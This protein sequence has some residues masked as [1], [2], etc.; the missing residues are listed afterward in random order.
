[1][2][3]G[4]RVRHYVHI[5]TGNYNPKTARIYTDLGLFTADPEIG[6]DVAE[7]FNFITGYGRP[8]DYRKVLVSPTTMRKRI[9]EEIEETIEAKRRGE[10]ARIA[11]KMNS[12]VD[13]RKIRALYEASQAG[14]RVDLN[15]RGICCLRPG[16]P[17]VSVSVFANSVVGRFLEHSRIYLFQRGD[18]TRVYVGSADLMPRNL[19]HRVELVAPVEEPALRDE[20]VDIVERALAD[21]RSSWTLDADGRWSRREPDAERPRSVQDE[22]RDWH[23]ARAAEHLVSA[24]E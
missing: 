10:P 18:E 22:L 19:D 20:A 12:L 17:G 21:D 7:M 2:R 1:R 9:R 15:I 11:M 5:G 16:V 14:V 3:E 24:S 8:A 13:A 23:E 6:A 4:D